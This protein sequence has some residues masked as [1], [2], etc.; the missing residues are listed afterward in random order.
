MQKL[1]TE[2]I[3]KLYTFTKKHYVD[4]YD[5]QTEL[6]DHLSNGIEAQW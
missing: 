5:L 2:Q 3:N 1:T 4:Y 6:V